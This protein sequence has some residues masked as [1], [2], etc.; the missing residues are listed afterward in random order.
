MG[1]GGQEIRILQ[2]SLG[3]RSRGYN[4]LIAAEPESVLFHRAKEQGID[5]FPV[6]FSKLKA[7]KTIYIL[8]KIIKN[9]SVSIVNT[10]S[11]LDAWLGGI[12]ARLASTPILRTRHLSTPIRKGMNSK[13]LYNSLADGIA[14]TSSAVVSKICYQ[15]QVNPKYCRC[16]PTG[17]DIQ[18]LKALS[19]DGSRDAFREAF[20]IGQDDFLVG[21]LC[22]IRSWKGICDFIQ[23]ALALRE[24]KEIKWVVIGGGARLE[25]HKQYIAHCGLEKNVIMVGHLENPFPILSAM[26]LFMLLSTK[27]EGISQAS[28]Q[29]A[30]LGKPL[31]TTTVGGLPEVCIDGV[32]GF[33]VSPHA[34]QEVAEK[35]LEMQKN[36]KLR[37][38]FGKKGRALVVEKFTK[39]N[40][41][42]A[43]EGMYY[44]VT[45]RQKN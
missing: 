5:V 28:L 14:T 29:A 22:M 44:T 13:L 9:H 8:Y 34:P 24:K 11:S 2:E 45:N 40:M 19:E 25:E 6:S 20:H 39:E 16:I 21:T 4:I 35:V 27:N 31:I 26:D 18:E 3:M 10:H 36:P 38:D 33:T 1:W 32:T 30:G 43:M 7:L 12:A 23:T 37:E 17:V 42:D 41:L 15:A